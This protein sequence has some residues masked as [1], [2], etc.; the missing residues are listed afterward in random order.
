MS[1]IIGDQGLN[2]L[3]LCVAEVLDIV[4]SDTYKSTD[5]TKDF[6]FTVIARIDGPMWTPEIQA[7]PINNS[8]KKIP[9]IGELI[10][11]FKLN[12]RLDNVLNPEQ[13]FYIST[14]DLNSEINHNSLPGYTAN[15]INSGKE[16]IGNTIEE[17]SISLL[18]P[19]EGDI[20]VEGRWGNSIRLG[21]TVKSINDIYTINPEIWKGD[22]VG[23]PITIISNGRKNKTEKDFVTESP[24]TCASSIY[25]TTTQRIPK[26][27]LNNQLRIGESESAFAGSQLIGFADRIVLKAKKDIIVL[28]SKMGIELNSPVIKMGTKS[29]KEPLLHSTATVKLLNTI[30]QVVRVGFKDS[31][32]R[33]C[34][35]IDKS[36][37]SPAISQAEQQLLNENIWID[38]HK[39]AK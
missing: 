28:D 9:L 21:S 36:L 30:L 3:Q 8:I 32:G 20:L 26:L 35:P 18:Q 25:L 34:T 23:D 37:L 38:K 7:K 11:V 39:D 17:K 1:N 13:W 5:K 4:K 6:M 16:V 12:S 24:E 27:K 10:L 31:S 22:T 19:Y 33:M 15:G 14:V 29:T 2:N